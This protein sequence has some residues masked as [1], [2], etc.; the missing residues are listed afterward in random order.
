M[1]EYEKQAQDFLKKFG[2]KIS[3]TQRD[4]NPPAWEEKPEYNRYRYRV[5]VTRKSTGKSLSFQFWDSINAYMKN[6]RPTAYDLLACL[7]S[8]SYPQPDFKGFCGDFGYDE[9]S[10]KAHALWGRV[11]RF[12]ERINGFFTDAELEDL[13]EI[14]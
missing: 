7:G 11:K 12:A 13:R 4:T 1:S 8:E 6:K 10:R 2:L 14:N 5:K 9:D 3:A